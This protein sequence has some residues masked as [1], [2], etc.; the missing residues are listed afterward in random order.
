MRSKNYSNIHR[1][2]HNKFCKFLNA[3]DIQLRHQCNT[4]LKWVLW[5]FLWV[6][7]QSY[8]ILKI[9][10]YIYSHSYLFIRIFFFWYSVIPQARAICLEI[11]WLRHCKEIQTVTTFLKKKLHG[12]SHITLSKMGKEYTFGYWWHTHFPVKQARYTKQAATQATP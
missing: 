10:T 6:R 1:H 12:C 11:N 8:I 7:F 4:V 9:F 2:F 5:G 3:K